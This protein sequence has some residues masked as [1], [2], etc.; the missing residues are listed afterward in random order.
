MKPL[1]EVEDLS[2]EFD[3]RRGRVRAIDQVSFTVTPG[4]TLALVGESGCG[5][6]ITSLA[7]MG[8]LP[9]NGRVAGGAIRFAGEDLTRATDARLR[10]LRG[11]GISMVFQDPMSSL[12]PCFTVGFQIEET[13]LA[14]AREPVAKAERR[15][16]ALE[17]L[18]QVGI[19]AARERLDAFPHQLSG[20]MSQRVMIALAIACR[21]RLLI[22]DEPTTALDVTIQ[23]Q[24]LALLRRLQ[25]EREMGMILIT[26]DL[27]LVA[28]N[29][30]RVHVMY[31]GQVVETG[32]TARVLRR[33][34][35]PY[36][37]GLLDSR[38]ALAHAA[39]SPENAA[40]A[41]QR[42]RLPSIPG[43]VPDLRHRPSGCQLHPRCRY[44]QPAC[45]QA[46]PA[47]LGEGA[48]VR[49]FHP[50]AEADA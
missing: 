49:C 7:V 10:E 13:I 32:A 29:A 5:K 30:D 6:S 40:L 24:I 38:P 42:P 27:G 47:L 23:A 43:V 3:T 46:A 48:A 4:E 11:A 37:R 20:G 21:P 50:L 17:L 18:D 2:V 9:A 22:A 33:P 39:P 15:R 31:A 35:H 19:P 34:R 25:R 44:A 28:Q 1:L 16:R 36:T 26:H 41:G 12:N 8:L 45:A 14:H